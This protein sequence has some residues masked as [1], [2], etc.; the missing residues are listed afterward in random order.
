VKVFLLHPD[1]DFDVKPELRDEIFEAMTSGNLFAITNARR[2]LQRREPP[3]ARRPSSDDVLVQDLELE[4]LWNVMANG[5]EFLYEMA[6]RALLSSLHDPS[7]I[8]YRQEVLA[9]CIEH[10]EIARQLYELAIDALARE[11]NVGPLWQT[12][13]PDS[14]LHRSVGL[15]KEH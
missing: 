7:E 10:S 4:T 2:N 1:R 14:I 8:V 15:L 9:D 13:M 12:A 11:R 6:K 5:D 3:A